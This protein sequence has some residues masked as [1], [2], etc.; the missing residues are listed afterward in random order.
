ML[1]DGSV[2]TWGGEDLGGDSR[3]VQDQLNVVTWRD[4]DGGGDNSDVQDQLENVQQIQV[5]DFAVAAILRDGSVV[6]EQW[7]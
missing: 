6:S 2:V 7:W 1:G 5:N 3:D 4:A